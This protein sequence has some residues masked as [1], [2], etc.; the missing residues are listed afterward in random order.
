MTLYKTFSDNKL[1]IAL[2]KHINIYYHFIHWIIKEEKICLV[3]CSIEDM[4]AMSSPRPSS[5]SKSSILL[6]NLASP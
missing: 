6:V 5:H 1:A 4:V 2:T 3:Y